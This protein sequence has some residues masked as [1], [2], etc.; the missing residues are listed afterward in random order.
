MSKIVKDVRGQDIKAGDI[1]AYHS[2]FKGLIIGMVKYDS[3]EKKSIH[4]IK[5][6]GGMHYIHKPY[7]SREDTDILNLSR[8]P[9]DIDSLV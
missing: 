6:D 2:S 1:I 5:Q 9:E 3:D 7:G 8:L 4:L